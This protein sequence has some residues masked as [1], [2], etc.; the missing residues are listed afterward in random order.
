[1]ELDSVKSTH[2]VEGVQDWVA[3]EALLYII[4]RSLALLDA[5]YV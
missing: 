4:S 5:D 3:L 2:Q 1:M